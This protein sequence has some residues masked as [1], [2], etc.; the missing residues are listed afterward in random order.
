MIHAR[1]SKYVSKPIYQ[2]CKAALEDQNLK[3]TIEQRR[4]VSLYALEG[5]LNGLD[6]TGKNHDTYIYTMTHMNKKSNEFRQKIE[7]ATGLFKTTINN[8]NIVHDFPE[9]FLRAIAVDPKNPRQGPWK[10]TL[11]PNIASQFLMYCPDRELRWN[12]WHANVNRGSLTGDNSLRTSSIL[13]DLREYK[14]DQ[15]KALGFKSYSHLSMETKLAGSLEN[16]YRVMD[17][18][19]Q[20]ARPAQEKEIAELTSFAQDRGFDGRLLQWDIDYWINKH[21]RNVLNYKSEILREYFP[22]PQVL[23][24]LFKLIENLFDVRIV[25]GRKT[26]V[27]HT[28]VRFLDVIDLKGNSREPIAHIYLDP[29]ARGQNK[30]LTVQH[31]GWM[32]GIQNKS[33]IQSTKPLV[34]LIFNFRPPTSEVPSFL[35]FKDVSCLFQK[36]G[37]AL[38]NVLTNVEYGDLSG[39]ANVEWDA[40]NVSGN[41]MVNWLYEP[42]IIRSISGHYK[43]NE[44]LNDQQIESITRTRTHMAGYKL[45]KE[46]YL[47][48]FDLE[49]HENGEFWVQIMNRLWS[50][51]FVLPRDHSD[52]HIT[53]WTEI[54]VDNW[55]AAYYSH[56]WSDMIAADIYSAFQEIPQNDCVQEKEIAMR[57]KDTFLALGGSVSAGEIFRRFRGR[58]PNSRS[59]L[60]NIG[61]KTQTTEETVK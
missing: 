12:V 35:T 40:V 10:I 26:D 6:L 54:F 57:F 59:L 55:A 44:P 43:T 1:S 3:L 33:K 25:E 34:A 20:I 38:Q 29:Y 23:K 37:N 9:D 45:C 21:E 42:V 16:V 39:S 28:D 4:L 50:S 7:L 41:F 61:L 2:A 19:L 24:G 15:A 17:S 18:L 56:L 27:W 52:S 31:E 32:V 48:R 11:E 13:E 51:H 53:S 47:G 22:L 58:D 30:L 14:I 8:E 36:V 5:R 49:L 60:R 46:L